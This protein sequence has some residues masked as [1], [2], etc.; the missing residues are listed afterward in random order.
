MLMPKES[1]ELWPKEKV[2]VS[3][4]TNLSSGP[5]QWQLVLEHFLL[6]IL[7]YSENTNLEY[8]DFLF[9]RSR[10]PSMAGRPF[11]EQPLQF[12]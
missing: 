5:N 12:L 8:R 6:L 9:I 4:Y 1:K 10:R 3:I 7:A 2:K 11:E